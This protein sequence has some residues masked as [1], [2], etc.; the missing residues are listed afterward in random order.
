MKE[1]LW[2]EQAG[3]RQSGAD[4][5]AQERKRSVVGVS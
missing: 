4:M 3:T 2:R 5:C 1:D